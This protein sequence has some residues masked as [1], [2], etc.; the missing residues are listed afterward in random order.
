MFDHAWVFLLLRKLH[1]ESNRLV[2]ARWSGAKCRFKLKLMSSIM[3]IDQFLYDLPQEL[4][5]QQPN[6]KRSQSRLLYLNRATGEK[7]DLFFQDLL[8]LLTAGDVLV[9]NDTKVIPARLLGEKSTGG[10]VEVLVERIVNDHTVLAHVRANRSPKPGNQLLLENTLTVHVVARVDDLF[11]LSFE[12]EQPVLQILETIGRL[13]LPPYVTHSP[14]ALDAERYQ[15]VF[16][17]HP[18][19]VAAPTAGLH[20]DDDLFEALQSKNIRCLFVTLHV[21]AGTF[22]P[23][24]VN[25]IED[26]TM[27]SEYLA[28]SEDVC[29]AINTAKQQGRRVIAVGTTVVRCLESVATGG[30][31]APFRGETN[32]FIYPGFEFQIID[33]LVTNF[34]LPGSTLLLLVSAFAKQQPIL[35]AYQHAIEQRY[36][37]FSYGDAMFIA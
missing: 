4:I 18:G 17:R 26:H 8:S 29:Q 25:T 21:G 19:A 23:L 3:N 20:F 1:V 33:G 22:Q 7:K 15:T 30:R 2:I 10:Q 5:A 11:E 34:H 35:A 12:S 9:F 6:E 24:R 16:A 36:R 37:F 27:H 28:I 13:P 14:T 31:V 32:I